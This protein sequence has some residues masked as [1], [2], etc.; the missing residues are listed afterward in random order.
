MKPT[1]KFYLRFIIKMFHHAFLKIID[2]FFISTKVFKF[3]R[4]WRTYFG[5]KTIIKFSKLW[6]KYFENFTLLLRRFYL[7]KILQM[8]I[9]S[10]QK[11]AE[12]M[13]HKKKI[14]E[15]LLCLMQINKE[16]LPTS[17]GYLF[18]IY[19]DIDT[20]RN[21]TKEVQSPATYSCYKYIFIRTNLIQN[22]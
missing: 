5:F 18:F 21:C 19:N 20:G 14:N 7:N 16:I 6:Q 10:L 4:Y 17:S 11:V 22:Q 8:K 1:L 15:V 9:F 2:H 13:I 12:L 3:Y